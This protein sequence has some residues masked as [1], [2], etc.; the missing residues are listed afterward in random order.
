MSIIT[1][2]ESNGKLM[3]ILIAKNITA[4]KI[5]GQMSH[6]KIWEIQITVLFSPED[7]QLIVLFS[8]RDIQLIVLF[9]SRGMQLIVLFSSREMQLFLFSS[10][11]IQLTFV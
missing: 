10:R 7:M 11:E 4:N 2:S 5:C 9:S 6:P 3:N 8:S 1:G